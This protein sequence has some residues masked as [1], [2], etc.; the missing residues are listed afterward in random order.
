M[1]KFILSA[2]VIITFGIYTSLVKSG[3][4]S[5]QLSKIKQVPVQ[6]N[7]S[8][9]STSKVSRNTD[10]VYIRYY[11]SG[12][13]S[14]ADD[15]EKEKGYYKCTN[16]IVNPTETP[17]NNTTT[18]AQVVVSPPPVIKP[19]SNLKWQDGTYIGDSVDAYY[20]N[21][22]VS[23]K[24]SA[25][26]ITDITFLDYPQDRRTSLQKSDYAMPILKREAISAQSANVDTVSSV[27]Y[28]S[29]AFIR[30]LSSALTQA[31]V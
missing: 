1:K 10:C 21:V 22:Q 3:S 17:A 8:S 30:S 28:T 12:E 31:R 26:R 7:N 6:S 4:F 18:P 9:L 5:S 19:K 24:I 14:Y 13:E 20:G 11:E 16:V 15:E 2:L 29:E 23:V 27:T 25:D